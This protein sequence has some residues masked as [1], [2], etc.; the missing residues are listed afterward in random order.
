MVWVS[1]NDKK[2]ERLL[3]VAALSW[4]LYLIWARTGICTAIEP[5]AASQWLVA[6]EHDCVLYQVGLS[7]RGDLVYGLHSIVL[8]SALVGNYH[9]PRIRP[10]R[11][12]LHRT[13]CRLPSKRL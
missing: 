12:R 7:I 11:Y 1:W 6:G 3:A 5:L 2:C 8:G 9:Q 10:L 13:V 4:I